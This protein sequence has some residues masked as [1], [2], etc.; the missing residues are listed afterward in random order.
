M[1]L[2]EGG[3]LGDES[4]AVFGSVLVRGADDLA[5]WFQDFQRREDPWGAV[6]K[7]EAA[8]ATGKTP[9]SKR[10]VCALHIGAAALATTG[11]PKR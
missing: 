7:I 2:E 5:S 1:V 9:P 11:N 8:E 10:A 6:G 3:T 4:S